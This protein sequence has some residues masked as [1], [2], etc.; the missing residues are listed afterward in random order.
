M[1]AQMAKQ[2]YLGKNLINKTY[3]ILLGLCFLFFYFC[4]LFIYF[5]DDY[6]FIA[7][8]DNIK[9]TRVLNMLYFCVVTVTNS[10]FRNNVSPSSLMLVDQYPY[11]V[12]ISAELVFARWWVYV[13]LCISM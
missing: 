9:A 7:F 6:F 12:V 2:K 1:L 8:I 3:N 4:F 11:V 13:T 5:F 10:V